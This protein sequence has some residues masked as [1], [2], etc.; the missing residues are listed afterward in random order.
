M[1]ERL[2]I[3]NEQR[4]A[5]QKAGHLS[6]S[7]RK[8][9]RIQQY[10]DAINKF[11]KGETIDVNSLPDPTNG[12]PPLRKTLNKVNFCIWS[13]QYLFSLDVWFKVFHSGCIMHMQTVTEHEVFHSGCIKYI[14]HINHVNHCFHMQ[15]FIE[16][17]S[18]NY[19]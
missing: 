18:K 11:K 9:R 2:K 16:H 8:T 13:L 17:K 10:K 5:A 19:S 4:L 1:Q 6:L 14:K 3:Y 7:R 12:T 15:T